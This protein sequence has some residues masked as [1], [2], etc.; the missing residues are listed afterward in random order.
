MNNILLLFYQLDLREMLTDKSRPHN[1]DNNK[2]PV[3]KPR[4]L[5]Q[6]DDL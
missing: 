3:S 4:G 2:I 5:M 6:V 1:S